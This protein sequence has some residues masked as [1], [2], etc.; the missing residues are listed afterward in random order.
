MIYSYYPGCSLDGTAK[1]YNLSLKAICPVL[2]IELKEVKDWICCGATSAHQTSHL[3]SVSLPAKSLAEVE[4]EGLDEVVVPCAACFQRLKTAR[5]EL[6]NSPELLKDVSVIIDYP[7]E[8]KVKVLHPLE[9]FSSSNVLELA[10]RNIKKDLSKLKVVCYYGC[11]LTRPPKVMQF[12][13]Y[14]YPMSMDEILSRIGVTVLDWSYK[15]DCCGASL[16][17]TK[18]EIVLRLINNIF[19]NAEAVGADAI[20]VGCTLCHTNLDTRQE[21]AK[22]VYNKNYNLPIFFFTQLMGL[23][24]GMSAKE[25]SLHTHFVSPDK[26]LSKII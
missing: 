9:I 19:E 6:E 1:E 10:K 12:D 20:A 21:E 26:L 17:L 7:F 3:L 2:G 14:E 5:Y 18:S 15:T 23:A 24:F 16:A 13:N 22:K 8:N 25:L 11:L 4:K